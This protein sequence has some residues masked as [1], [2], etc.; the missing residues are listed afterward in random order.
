MNQWLSLRR[1]G[2]GWAIATVVVALVSCRPAPVE[3]LGG[4]T[5]EPIQDEQLVLRN[6][7]L[8]QADADGNILWKIN[9]QLTR[10]S[11]D[12]QVAQLE[13]LT[14]NLLQDGQVILK[15]RAAGGEIRLEEDGEKVFLRGRIEA[16]DPRN[17]LTLRAQELDWLPR[18][19]R[20]AA[21]QQLQASHPQLELVASEASYQTREQELE[22][23]GEIVAVAKEQPLEIQSEQLTWQIA[24]RQLKG[25][26]G[27]ELKRY[28]E[29]VTLAA[30]NATRRG[31]RLSLNLGA[32]QPLIL[33]PPPLPETATDRIVAEES[34]LNLET[35]VVLLKNSVESRSLEPPLQIASDSIVWDLKQR[36][37]LA[38]QPVQILHTQDRLAI[39]ANQGFAD[40]DREIVQLSG[41]A[42]GRNPSNRSELSADE[43]IWQIPSRQLEATGQVIYRQQDPP[44]HLVGSR[45]LGNLDQQNITITS[46]PGQRVVTN[47]VP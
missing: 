20:V 4:E 8:E 43:I 33:A 21:R 41:G 9:A 29:P 47:I 46:S 5:V 11:E 10:Y 40:L 1:G 13:E 44:L 36:T 6:A 3:D 27:I 37:V 7:T 31:A 25:D 28:P 35:L 34:A 42:L 38:D 22:A 16:T 12:K 23:F 18:E 26:R 19:D 17:E 32:G 39:A 15:V 2:R 30:V 45:A 14:G 24:A